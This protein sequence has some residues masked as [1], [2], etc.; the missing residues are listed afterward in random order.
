[1]RHGHWIGWIVGVAMLALA[2]AGGPGHESHGEGHHDDPGAHAQCP[3][4]G[5]GECPHRAS[6]KCPHHESGKCPHHAKHHGDAEGHG[7]GG[8]DHA[9]TRVPRRVVPEGAG[10]PLF[11]DLGDFSR[12]IEASGLAPRYFTQGLV[13]AYGF[14]HAEA[15]R[16]FEE[17]SAQ[18]PGCA[19]CAWGEALVLGPNIN[20]PM[21]PA[22]GPVAWEAL[23]RAL[24]LKDA[25]AP[26]EA[27]LIDALAT[28]YA[29][30]A[31]ADR[32][33]L[34]LAYANAMREVAARFPDDAD[35]QTLFAEALMD[36]MPWDYYVD[37]ET[38]KPATEEV[39][40]ALE[41]VM[42]RDPDHV[43]A[44]HLYIHAV[45]PS[46]TPGRGER[47]ADTL[48]PLSPGAGHLVH[49]PSHIYLRVGRYADASAA[50]ERAAAADES[51][52]TQCRAQGFYPASYYPHNVHFLY[53]SSAFEGRSA[54]SIEAARKLSA[55][56]TPEMVAAVPIVE[57]FVPMELYA[58]ARFGRWSEI[59]AAPRPPA[60]WRYANGAWHYARGM[61]SAATGAIANARAELAEVEALAEADD[62]KGLT[63]ASGSTPAQ[64]LTIGAKILAARIEGEAG[65]WSEALP[66]LRE[67]VAL[68]DGLPYTEPPPWY[69]PTRE[70]LGNALLES[71]RPAEA[72]SVFRKELT[73]TPRNGWSLAGL[74]TSLE[75]QGKRGAAREV[76]AERVSV[77]ERADVDLPAPVF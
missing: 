14:N 46:N 9:H 70:A 67:A 65:R 42:D 26:V 56:M 62:L 43:G 21:D 16:S 18:D 28:R 58:L 8:K 50:N 63:F 3:L 33:E 37:P 75:A 49:M 68:Q 31:P 69:F 64:L 47:A 77:W 40:A 1:M 13:L 32:S 23:Q 22:D 60:E 10:A 61:A 55:N 66:H 74:V 25:S 12:S 5:S 71:G 15:H 34:D 19:I 72:E 6:G 45:E 27:A 29:E 20:K 51:Y 30:R 41:A 39:V 2:C 54:V 36:T 38:P 35:V 11:N 17:A 44:L 57:E 53:A 76:E 7:H 59:L 4:H 24:A 73:K 48:G 52:I